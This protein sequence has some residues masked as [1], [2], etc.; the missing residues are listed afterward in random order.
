MAKK[1][2]KIKIHH[3][4]HTLEELSQEF[5]SECER[6]NLSSQSIKSYNSKIKLLLLC[7][8]NQSIEQ[9]D[10]DTLNKQF[11]SWLK[12]NRNFSDSSIN[13]TIKNIN[14]FL[15][16]VNKHHQTK[17]HL[18]PVKQIKTIKP[19]YTK[20]QIKQLTNFKITDGTLQSYYAM[21][22]A[23]LIAINTGSRISTICAIKVSHIHKDYILFKHQKNRKEV[24]YPINRKL[25]KIIKTYIDT[26]G[27]EPDMYLIQNSLGGQH[28]SKSLGASF[29]R[30]CEYQNVELHKFHS[31]RRFHA[32]Q[33]LLKTKNLHLVQQSL[34]HSSILT[35]QL[36]VDGLGI[37]SYKTELEN[38]NLMGDDEE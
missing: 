36:Y 29:V 4:Q 33:L 10:N 23:T 30:Y 19:V 16:Y 17:L 13:I 7:F 3:H 31:L 38:I 37:E 11:L 20:A 14:T 18:E 28:N 32:Q 22:I 6:K 21:Y 9:L 12:K 1:I 5:L 26:C 24:Q 34:Q 27:L 25:Y 35:S 8:D 15:N 2:R